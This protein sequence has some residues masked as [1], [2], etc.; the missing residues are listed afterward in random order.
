MI[1]TIQ[2]QRSIFHNVTRSSFGI[3]IQIIDIVGENK[4]T[5]LLKEL[6][7]VSHSFL[8]ICSKHLFAAVE[9][10]DRYSSSKKRFIKLLKSRPN[11][12][13]YISKL[14]YKFGHNYQPL[15]L[16]GN[17]IHLYKFRLRRSSVPRAAHPSIFRCRR[18]PALIDPSKFPTNNSS[19]QLPHNQRLKFGLENIGLFSEISVTPHHASSYH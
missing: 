14:T 8:Q 13:K 5:V 3:I 6:A 17:V 1:L 11:V 19:S 15:P 4:D 10:H 18:P 2:V 16:T 7:L 9:I 12:V